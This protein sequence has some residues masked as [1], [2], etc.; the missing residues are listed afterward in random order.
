MLA[1][2]VLWTS[3]DIKMLWLQR[4]RRAVVP[5]TSTTHAYTSQI[6]TTFYVIHTPQLIQSHHNFHWSHG[7]KHVHTK[8]YVFTLHNNP[9]TPYFY[10]SHAQKYVHT[11]IYVI[12]TLQQSN[13]TTISIHHTL[14]N[15][16]IPKLPGFTQKQVPAKQLDALLYVSNCV[17]FGN[18][19][20]PLTC[21][22]SHC[23]LFY[24]PMERGHTR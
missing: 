9:I 15:M 1:V 6:H 4:G 19:P 7:H 14:T 10:W 5:P 13:H 22:V 18:V 3:L 11:K 24:T 23:T 17:K 2:G 8:I 16:F 21:E 12:H 20:R